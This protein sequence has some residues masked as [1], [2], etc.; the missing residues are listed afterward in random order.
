MRGDPSDNLPGVPGVGEKTA[1]KLITSYGGLDGVFANIDAQTP[2]LRASLAEHEERVRK[3]HEIMVLRRD[4]PIELPE[5][6]EMQ[7][8]MN[9]VQRL[10][11]FL[12]F[13]TFAERLA[14]ALGPAAVVLSSEEREQLVAEVTVSES[15]AASA[16]TLAGL[17]DVAVA[18]AW[19]GEAGRSLLAGLAVVT[20][21]SMSAVTWI[22]AA[23]LADDG[24][25]A[26]LSTAA[27]RAHDAKA[28]MRSLLA[29]EPPIDLAGLAL[30]T[31]I[32]AYLLDPAEA[33]YQLAHLVERYTRF[34]L[35][36]DEPAAKGQL[37]LD[38]TAADPSTVAGREALA[39]HHLVEPVTT[40]LAADGMADLYA[41]I[42]NPLVRVLARMEH[43]GIAVDGTELR[44]LNDRLTAEVV[45]LNAEL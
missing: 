43:V 33:R 21:P 14:E 29:H 32:A 31:A 38:G 7:P 26:A 6:L 12:E 17:D 10:F 35:A 3:N 41:T 18:A 9:E 13:R 11:D 20:D 39:V 2:K 19:E 42:E 30:D 24:V 45:K 16:A 8:N 1:A 27:V 5:S 37:D 23:H 44:A 36:P 40:R 34:A 25:A 22:P 15:P 28:L 4:A